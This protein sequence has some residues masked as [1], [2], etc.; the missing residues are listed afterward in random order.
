M[1][2]FKVVVNLVPLWTWYESSNELSSALSWMHEFK[3]CSRL[4]NRTH[5]FTAKIATY[6]RNFYFFLAR[7]A[8]DISF[9]FLAFLQL[10]IF[11]KVSSTSIAK[12]SLSESCSFSVLSPNW[13]FSFF[14]TLSNRLRVS[15]SITFLG[16][17]NNLKY[18]NEVD[19]LNLGN[20]QKGF[21]DS[22]ISL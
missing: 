8:F 2:R 15:G 21:T 4:A 3:G 1:K 16:V 12:W 7:H 20:I 17:Q 10:T 19:I 13:F 5:Y 18:P 22:L 11:K 9:L 6:N 14:H